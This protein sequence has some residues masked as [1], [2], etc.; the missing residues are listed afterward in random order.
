MQSFPW[1]L[2]FWPCLLQGFWNP[3]LALLTWCRLQYFNPLS[4]AVCLS[5]FDCLCCLIASGAGELQTCHLLE[6]CPLLLSVASWAQVTSTTSLEVVCDC[7]LDASTTEPTQITIVPG[8][9]KA[10]R[11]AVSVDDSGLICLELLL[12]MVTQLQFVA[13]LQVQL[14]KCRAA[15]DTL[16]KCT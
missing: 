14:S 11:V 3:V 7:L 16:W 1:L 12:H 5:S 13:I 6:S 2:H 15:A 8:S 9:G 10:A 4:L